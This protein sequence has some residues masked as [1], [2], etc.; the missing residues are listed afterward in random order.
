MQTETSQISNLVNIF[1]SGFT[2]LLNTANES[3]KIK[4]QS[5]LSSVSSTTTDNQIS[6][7]TQIKEAFE[8]LARPV[9]AMAV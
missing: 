4:N 3:C 5:L 8:T 1:N 9:L 2:G 6:C 7:S